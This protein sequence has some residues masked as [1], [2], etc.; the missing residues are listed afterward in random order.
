MKIKTVEEKQRSLQDVSMKIYYI[1]TRTQNIAGLALYVQ[2]IML[3][4]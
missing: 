1:A 3:S 2:Y 4:F